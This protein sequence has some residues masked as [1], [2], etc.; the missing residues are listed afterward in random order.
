MWQSLTIA[1][2]P[3][4]VLLD[5]S[6]IHNEKSTAFIRYC[7]KFDIKIIFNVKY[8]PDFNGIE[9][10]WGWAKK[11]IRAKLD[12][13]KANGL[14]WNELQ[15]VE[16]IMGSIPKEVAINCTRA[17]FKNIEKGVP[18]DSTRF[19]EGPDHRLNLGNLACIVKPNPSA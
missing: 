8:R 19:T 10:V 3:I 9:A 6:S 15:L 11:E 7:D 5:N 1:M 2:Q 12:W 17:G 4:A 14:E 13:F 18:V 16:D